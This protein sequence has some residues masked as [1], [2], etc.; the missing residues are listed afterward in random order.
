MTT[1]P[2]LWR[3]FAN[4][5]ALIAYLK[6]EFPHAASIDDHVAETRGGRRVAE[7]LLRAVDPAAYRQTRNY[8]NGSVTRLSP[9]IR[10]G[11][12]SLA[13]VRDW[14]LR[15][16]EQ[17]HEAAK[18]VNELGWRDY[19]QRVYQVLGNDIWADR[20]PYK[21]G[22]AP[23][24]YETELPH[25][26]RDGTTGLACLDAFSCDLRETGYLH[27]HARMWLAAYI[28][29]WRR[30]R[31]Q[32]GAS[33]FLEHLLDG[34]PASNNLSWQWVAST[35]SHKPYIFNRA[36]LEQYAGGQYCRDC[37]LYS[38]CDFEGSYDE[39][40]ATLFGT[41]E[42]AENQALE[43]PQPQKSEPV[44][45]TLPTL[46]GR[47]IVW[48]HGDNLNPN[49]PA[50]KDV[51]AAPAIW[52]WDDELLD[53]WRISLKRVLFLYECLLELPTTIRRGI[54]VD[55]IEAFAAQHD[56]HHVITAN[57]PSPRFQDIL[58]QLRQGGLTVHVL[59]DSGL[60]DADVTFDLRR[61]SRY[62]QVARK[63]ALIETR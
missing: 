48:V 55:E 20:E 15:S 18:L 27:N 50:L 51:P 59:K 3:D 44:Q 8:L 31:W 24:E 12:L 11:V 26:I 46:D 34:D 43:L 4:R 33:W 58:R 39:I 37:P 17:P 56:A 16:A 2:D 63:Y 6:T 52:V 41:F 40:G 60:V 28:V 54:V 13:E 23:H 14:A 21:T 7:A 32:A 30:V 57:S 45:Q 42:P 36:N 53:Q 5:A 19:F 1:S 9:Y 35:F 25:D 61:F 22:F 29:H 10:H 38:K 47:A 62:W 49:N